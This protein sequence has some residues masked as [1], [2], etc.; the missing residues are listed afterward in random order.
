MQTDQRP[1]SPVPKLDV[2]ALCLGLAAVVLGLSGVR[3]GG[4]TSPE[5]ISTV[6]QLHSL[7]DQQRSQ[8]L[9]FELRGTVLCYDRD[10]HQLY[11]QGR[12]G[13]TYFPPPPIEGALEPGDQVKISGR[14]TAGRQDL[15]LTNLSVAVVEQAPLP[16][17]KKVGLT[18]LSKSVGDW[19]ELTARVRSAENSRGRL[20]LTVGD[21]SL[22][23]LV[24]LMGSAWTNECT[25][26]IGALVR[27][28]G[29][30]TAQ[31]AE[32]RSAPLLLVP[33]FSE[34]TVLE[35]PPVRMERLP[36]VSIDSLLNR[37][38]GSWTNEP[39]HLNGLVVSAIPGD[40]ML[41]RDPTGMILA[42]V[43]Q[44]TETIPGE[45]V[46][47]W[48]YL[49]AAAEQPF[50]ADASF[51]PVAGST[52]SP[53]AVKSPANLTN[54]PAKAIGKIALL[55]E[56]PRAQLEK[57]I[58]V[59]FRGVVTYSDPDWNTA[60]VQDPSGAIYVELGQTNIVL[61]QSVEVSGRVTFG[62]F[63]PAV[64]PANLEVLGTTNLPHPVSADLG[65]V[66]EGNLDAQWVEM[67]GVVRGAFAEWG[68]LHFSV[69]T[70]HGKF[71]VVVPGYK[72]T[73]PPPGLLDSRVRLRGVCGS[74]LNARS[75]VNGVTLYVPGL[76]QIK[77]L[78]R[79]PADPFH[80]KATGIGEVATFDPVRIAGSRIKVAGVV[81]LNLP[82]QGLY[83]QDA[84][85][86]IRVQTRLGEFSDLRPGD[87]VEVLGFPALGDFSP[88]LEEP[89]I[90]R[91]GLGALPAPHATT[92]EQIL[93]QGTNDASLVRLEAQLLQRVPRSAQ[94]K[95]VLQEGPIIFT[96]QLAEGRF[97]RQVSAWR[98]GTLLRLTGLCLIQGSDDHSP[99]L[100]RVLLSNP[101][102]LELV[103][104]APAWSLRDLLV[105]LGAV[106]L[107]GVLALGWIVALRRQVRLRTAELRA[108]QGS[109]QLQVQHNHALAE[110]GRRLNQAATPKA[111]ALII[112][113]VADRLIGWDSCICDLYNPETNLTAHVLN[114]DIVDGQRTELQPVCLQTPPS[115]LARR[116]IDGGPQLVLRTPAELAQI[117]QLDGIPFGDT[118][119]RS[120]SILYVPIRK[121]PT[122]V[123]LLS[124][125]SYDANDY[126]QR[127]LE[128]LQAL[129]DHC[130][131]AFERIR[132]HQQLIE[133]SRQ[134]GMAE[135]ATGVLH[136]VGNVLNSVNV[137]IS[138]LLDRTR[139]S[140]ATRLSRISE[141]FT[142][143]SSDLAQFLTQ[144]P[145]GRMIPAYLA[146]FAAVVSGD[147]TQ[148]RSELESL[149]RHVE[150]IKEIVAMQQSYA[151][152]AGIVENVPAA[153]LVEDALRLNAGALAR[154]QVEVRRVYPRH[155]PVLSCDKHKVLQI[156][157]NLIRNA[158]YACDES[159]RD[160]KRV[161]VSVT[162]GDGRVRISVADNGTGIAPENLTR[163][164]SL[165]FSTRKNGHGFGLHS[166]ALA[167][168]EL[169]GRLTVESEGPGRG[170]TFTLELPM[171]S[172]ISADPPER[173]PNQE[174]PGSA[175]FMT[176]AL[177]PQSGFTGGADYVPYSETAG[178]PPGETQ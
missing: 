63:G 62:G 95:L 104:P 67:S 18:D 163:I 108:S 5:P 11:V 52:V 178:V 174:T 14:T 133:L 30:D 101:S 1:V 79:A 40:S 36:V 129:A 166:G 64:F 136:N 6:S 46:D 147:E 58:Q 49:Q 65:D 31:T 124:I 117:S 68:H 140:H 86:G 106:S 111:A 143:H 3:S 59:R 84:S 57:G 169:G 69:M 32:G 160:D 56:W 170:A 88:H 53:A 159:G 132:A 138:L 148:I 161:I 123:G 158:K 176:Q 135:V 114:L 137:S 171:G 21:P 44:V 115:R 109:L 25:S 85:G 55:R 91:I 151:R 75:Q 8:G 172:A 23:C 74:D 97:P 94:P 131:G 72:G 130:S 89:L 10:W 105:T 146:Q 61:G 80:I 15:P 81:T 77:T 83:L 22:A 156:L 155:L 113:E 141:L 121:S 50:L 145:K 168:K 128:T 127:D 110:L 12:A 82:G 4:A 76:R 126:T 175:D 33:S 39:V 90:R 78:E 29:V 45:R 173:S 103:N 47:L 116:A 134:V 70:R 26:Y 100:F 98:P 27:I 153:E 119:R 13:I 16:E 48:G 51:E 107:V 73:N 149:A 93:V 17:A 144:D 96:A 122:V 139:D 38:L 2:G 167:A 7:S 9:P 34:L 102:Q 152:L 37:E 112:A 154:H 20:T 99:Q 60:F 42:H 87:F 142:A 41:I 165:G 54:L 35:P 43:R 125:Q 28:R 118:N 120:A 177:Q 66:A 164:F 92:A 19:V 24:Y 71:D 162:K 157:I 150:H